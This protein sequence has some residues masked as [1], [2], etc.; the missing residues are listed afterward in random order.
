MSLDAK[1][2][3]LEKIK[4]KSSYS[5]FAKKYYIGKST[6][7]DMKRNENK[8]RNFT[9]DRR[10]FEKKENYKISS[11]SQIRTGFIYMAFAKASN[12]FNNMGTTQMLRI[13][14]MFERRL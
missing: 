10:H 9:E 14:L 12:I 3:I 8:I 6:I 5:F 11:K 4:D 1:L 13:E 7:C 2:K